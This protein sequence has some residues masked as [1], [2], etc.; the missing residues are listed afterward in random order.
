MAHAKFQSPGI[1]I[2]GY[3]QLS[4]GHREGGTQTGREGVSEGP[5]M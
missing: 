3:F 4:S 5:K 2:D 1:N